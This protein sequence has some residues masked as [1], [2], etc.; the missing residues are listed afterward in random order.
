MNTD[1]SHHIA[2]I[3]MAA[4]LPGAASVDEYWTNLRDGRSGLTRFTTDEL[5]ADGGNPE[6]LAA[7]G[8]VPVKGYL[9]GADAFDAHFFGYSPREA[10]VIDPQQRVFLE[11]AWEALEDAG[12]V[13]SRFE[14]R[15]GVFGAAGTNTYLL[16]NLLTNHDLLDSFG[17]YQV[18]Q[19]S[20]KDFLATRTAYKLGLTGPAVTVQTACSS[21]LT[22][23][24]F[25]CQSLLDGECDVALA[26]AAAV[27]APLRDGYPYQE[28]S[29]TSPDGHCRAFDKDAAGTV[30]G[31]GVGLVVLRRM[32]EV[33]AQTHVRAVIRGSALNNDGDDKVGYT[34]PSVSGQQAVIMEALD[35]AEV[36]ARSIG[37]VE[38]HGTGTRLGDPIE[39]AALTQAFRAG[40]DD[41]GFCGLG[42]A[43]SSVGHLDAAAGIPG[44][45]KTVLMLEHGEMVPTL[46][47]SEPNP[48]LSLVGSPFTIIDSTRPWDT[49]G[50]PRRAGVSSFGIGGTNVHLVL[51][52]APQRP[53]DKATA[54]D[55]AP[56]CLAL[57]GRT[58][59]AVLEAANS[60]AD[61]L[62]AHTEL[63]L[64]TVASSLLR[65]RTWLERRVAVSATGRDGALLAL[66]R[67][68]VD[69]V[70]TADKRA[71]V[72]F[73]FPGQGAQYPGM[74]ADL[75][76]HDADFAARL[77]RCGELFRVQLGVDLLELVLHDGEERAELLGQTQYTQPALFMIE[78][79]LA[80]WLIDHGVVP[81]A[82]IGHSIGEYVAACVG[83]VLSLDDAVLLVAARGRIV[84][85]MRAGAMLS[86][87]LGEADVAPYL[88]EGIEIAAVNSTGFCS[89]SGS[90]DSIA[91][92]AERMRADGI[93]CSP[94]KTSHGF[95]S[96]SMD[97][98]IERLA[99]VATG[100]DLH[101]PSITLYSNVTGQVLTS[102]Q[103]TDPVYWGQHLRRTVRFSDAVDALLADPA[104]V[105]VEVGP[106]RS[107]S[108]LISYHASW[109]P[110]RVA[111]STLPQPRRVG[112]DRVQMATALGTLWAAGV[113]DDENLLVPNATE[114]VALPAY[115]FQ[116]ERHWIDPVAAAKQP[117]RRRPTGPSLL[118]PTWHRLA[119]S[120]SEAAHRTWLLLVSDE[121]Q[122]DTLRSLLPAEDPISTVI[123]TQDTAW[124]EVLATVE[125]SEPSSAA[126]HIVAATGT[127]D[128][129]EAYQHL[130]ALG[131][132]LALVPPSEGTALTV[133]VRG[134]HEVLGT[135][136]VHA[137]AA[138]PAALCAVL[139][140]EIEGLSTRVVD[141][142]ST[143]ADLPE[144]VAD[145]LHETLAM[146]V[147]QDVAIR[148]AHA[149]IRSF[150]TLPDVAGESRLVDGGLYV[151]TGGLGGV[152]SAI[153]RR[154]AERTQ[155]S[156]IVLLQ[157][158][159]M[160]P[161]DDHDAT[162]ATRASED[163]VRRKIELVRELEELGAR[164]E[165]RTV[166]ITDAD[167]VR[168]V[169]AELA[170][171]GHR[172]D[173]VVHAAGLPGAGLLA[174][175][176][177][178]DVTAILG[179][180][181]EGTEAL[182]QALHGHDVGPFLLCSSVNS[183]LGGF[184]QSD[185]AAA[186]AYL[187]ARAS[188]L[189]SEGLSATSIGWSRWE[190]V[191]MAAHTD[192]SVGGDIGHP[193]L[194]RVSAAP[195]RETFTC[196]IS[197]AQS[198]FVDDHRLLGSGLVP[199]TA[200][201]ELVRGAL[202]GRAQG[203]TMV[204]SDILFLSPA[205]V[206]DGQERT[207][208]VVIETAPEGEFFTVRSQNPADHTWQDNATGR[209]T[210]EAPSEVAPQD[211]DALRRA[212]PVREDFHDEQ[213]VFDRAQ[214]EQWTEGPLKFAIGPRW[215]VLRRLE[216][217]EGHTFATLALDDE[218]RDDVTLFP[219]HPALLDIA[220]GVF[221]MD[222]KDPNYLPL[223]YRTLR[224]RHPLTSEVVVHTRPKGAVTQD[225]AE[226][227]STDLEILDPHGRVLV[228][229]EGY[230]VRV[231]RDIAA[232][233]EHI[234]GELER[235]VSAEDVRPTDSQL[236]MLMVGH[237]EQDMLEAF[238]RLLS[239]RVLPPHV[240]VV[241]DDFEDRRELASR[242]TPSMLQEQISGPTT[243]HPRP[244]LATE[245]AAPRTPLE[246]SVAAIWADLLGIEDV[247]VNDD[248]FELGG[249]SLAAVQIVTRIKQRLAMEMDIANFYESP[250]VARMAE[251]L[252][253][254]GDGAAPQREE[255]KAVSRTE[256]VDLEAIE[257]MDEGE[258][259]AYLSL[260]AADGN[261]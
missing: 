161:R 243:K 86:V 192:H 27:T 145:V 242:L 170:S 182:A 47:F 164:I 220:V 29:I 90:H 160:P 121:R 93:V 141:L 257:Q 132:H 237:T 135:E 176:N 105:F 89:L 204:L 49:S 44:L 40:T 124:A 82:M 94:L 256:E 55:D 183:I 36:D 218:F 78:Y 38:A 158:S 245:F 179:P 225:G 25:A 127:R 200:Y 20:D 250:T 146:G 35:I 224:Y 122:A 77:D 117:E 254:S 219:L 85:E 199:G 54:D 162:L 213:S 221:R 48:E 228:E 227:L 34:A 139:S 81:K 241:D 207:L 185:Y 107:L 191:G 87:Q 174:S 106:G 193:M 63:A 194:R 37:Y 136:E 97:P 246:A 53:A 129:R 214:A 73:V 181:V 26:G 140:Q 19:A 33:D 102:E 205:F 226:T 198:W 14:G 57:S 23:V 223:S 147:D 209:V 98:A 8:F 148:G 163:L 240:L 95:H 152:G 133:I 180:K 171:R 238:E 13:P 215:H 71:K 202:A 62:E 216:L 210:W 217:A 208:S 42:S 74:A 165:V 159:E 103:A 229:I 261:V 113:V 58:P 110:S 236:D 39:V 43:K 131:Q 5:L 32:E 41:E 235:V 177:L 46:D 258:L 172:L 253:P 119:S 112:T 212:H 109:T 99:Q 143:L 239:L 9:A 233:Q 201:I 190:G 104:T 196:T 222:A 7:E 126:L 206:P 64:A 84:S 187:D 144:A 111:V 100:V 16:N 255:I 186:N 249:H 108:T 118:V 151:V 67:L 150:E 91:A 2:I 75:Y 88:G 114:H 24:H 157:R 30:P 197:T 169:V 156:T 4:H 17:R 123:P 231:V 60:L 76:A 248:F 22:A 12:I 50:G 178:D 175:K 137:D 83:G 61:H 128:G 72:A 232:L 51:E 138:L 155:G 45:I 203:R 168:K 184:G 59:V 3:G 247:G 259:D 10:D 125:P 188:S 96:A 70:I 65:G 116:R 79:C 68:S 11:C 260:L 15:I 234:A 211:L 92:L 21:A 230:T 173:M 66:R 244:P 31:N 189:R 134:A 167:T 28:G 115:P 166:D 52:E 6:D 56:F 80:T 1:P 101:A 142:D 120:G 252:H 130:L 251:L 149:W 154:I 18:L 195:E 153:A 69:D